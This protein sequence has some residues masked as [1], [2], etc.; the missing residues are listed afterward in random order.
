MRTAFLFLFVLFFCSPTLSLAQS[1]RNDIPPASLP[2]E[3]RTTLDNYLS[4][5]R[6][7]KSLD[8]CAERFVEL[9]GGGL[10]NEDGR[11][12]RGTV[13]PYSL[14]KDFQNVRFYAHPIRI[15]RVNAT[16]NRSSGY[17]ASAIGGTIYKIWID[18]AKGQAGMPA[19]ISILAPE[20][21]PSI[22]S[23]RVVGIGSL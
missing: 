6:E 22:Q 17:G 14:K 13:K 20:G 1:R 2:A 11:S 7:S 4:L 18:K 10:V 15:T 3:V 23:P 9:A 5:L 12:L 19:P 21:H 16:P 8:D